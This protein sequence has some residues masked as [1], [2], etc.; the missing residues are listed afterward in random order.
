M[1]KKH[2]YK[3]TTYLFIILFS[4]FLPLT[5]N[6]Q[7]NN[8]DTTCYIEGKII[9]YDL[10]IRYNWIDSIDGSIG[11]GYTHTYNF[12]LEITDILDTIPTG[13][14]ISL[15]EEMY[16]VGDVME[17]KYNSGGSSY[18]GLYE[19]KKDRVMRFKIEPVYYHNSNELIY[20]KITDLKLIKDSF[21]PPL[22]EIY[23]RENELVFTLVAGI[24]GLV[25][26]TSL[27]AIVRKKK[28]K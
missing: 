18:S 11:G 10:N 8:T 3:I 1:Y 22:I 21:D 7:T 19:L 23:Y 15:C 14:D 28:S 2:P 16:K 20:Y 25:I 27:L 5:T 6:S 26:L 9:E 24:T 17:V 13:L 12:T 4:I